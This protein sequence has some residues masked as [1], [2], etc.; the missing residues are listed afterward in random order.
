[1][2][3]INAGLSDM[4][5]YVRKT[6]ATGVTK[7][8]HLSPDAVRDNS[9]TA[10]LYRLLLE[11]K[12]PQV[13]ATCLIAIG[14][15]DGYASLLDKKH[16]YSLLNRIK[17]FNEWSQCAVL[18]LVSRYR[19]SGS[20]EIFDIM[21]LL[22]DRLQHTNSAVV[23]ATTKVFLQ[24]TMSLPDIHQQVYERIKAPLLT[25]ISSAPPEV[26]YPVLGH[27]H[28]L[29]SRAP[30][31]YADD[32]KAFYCRYNDP[33]YVKK[34]KLEMLTLV[35]DASTNMYEIVTELS[36]YAMDVNVPLAR[37]AIRCIGQIALKAEDVSDIVDRLLQFLE[38]NTDHIT[39]ETLKLTK[40]LVR[41]YP[42]RAE[43]FVRA[44][45]SVEPTDV[46]E[47]GARAALIWILGEYGE[48]V[49]MAPY[50]LEPLLTHLEE[51]ESPSVRLELLCAACKLFFKRPPEMQKMLGAALTAG[52]ADT[53]QDVHDRALLYYRLLQYSVE[54]AKRVICF[55]K[56]NVVEF[57]EALSSEVKDKIFDEFNSLSVVYR[58]PSYSFVV[59][60]SEDETVTKPQEPQRA[61][62][63]PDS[64][65]L[66][67]DI[68]VPA[69]N[70][71]S[72]A[73]TA[74]VT[75]SQPS[76][77]D[78]LMGLDISGPPPQPTPE[79]APALQLNA[80]A[81]LPPPVF[82]QK[83]GVT[84]LT[85]DVT[86]QLPPTAA[87]LS[88]PANIIRQL[89]ASS[90]HCIA[91]G[92]AAPQFKMY[93]YGQNV[94]GPLYLSELIINTQAL[95]A[96]IKIKS[97]DQASSSEFLQLLRQCLSAMS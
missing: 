56:E 23:L 85:L 89:Q 72:S 17:E 33:I 52:L 96:S 62:S 90:I 67:D 44:V 13:V 6:A 58:Q 41:R 38:M 19:P 30:L 65:L 87:G 39:A 10:P 42:Q 83:W 74:A 48:Y 82:Q 35:A 59:A 16:V 46:G 24:L 94:N 2:A 47:P 20:D 3:P 45:E 55:P 91:S 12:D 31:L 97:D 92:G 15:I 69:S 81:S 26:A 78:D 43:E 34:I 1:V 21:N 28:L 51:E 50:M 40:D 79:P 11:D 66:D 63:M 86:E 9:L 60:S 77:L 71:G 73:S 57:S 7:L 75:A 80:Q 18:E 27:L 5:G 70:G 95:A 37:E 61:A 76:L 54:E 36:E 84:P 93:I 88:S 49:Q 8:Y 29:V 25:L 4:N 22:E 53:H 64:N 14:E 68:S 32:Y